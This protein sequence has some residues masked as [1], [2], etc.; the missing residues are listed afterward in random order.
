MYTG[1]NFSTNFAPPEIP[2]PMRKNI[3]PSD[4]VLVVVS[5]NS[6]LGNRYYAERVAV[7]VLA[8]DETSSAV[9]G[10]LGYG[11]YI[12]TAASK[13]VEPK[14]QVRMKDK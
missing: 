11:D 6:P 10:N 2:E 13:P 3:R 8:S 4:F 12:I 14:D 9:S 1:S 5:K 7:E